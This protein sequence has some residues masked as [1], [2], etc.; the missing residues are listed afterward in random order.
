MPTHHPPRFDAAWQRRRRRRSA[1]RRW[2]WWLLLALILSVPLALRLSPP[3]PAPQWQRIDQPFPVCRQGSSTACVVDGDTVMFGKRR[4]RLTG[5]DAPEMEGACEA[6]RGQALD[7]RDAL[8]RWLSSAPF[9]WDGGDD[10]PR[11][12]YARELRGVRRGEEAL[13]DT[14]IARGLAQTSGWGNDP[15]AWCE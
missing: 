1:W 12:Q 3:Q 7:A 4:I 6:E 11:D 15:Q 5:F 2:R 14:M 13:A 9:E 8:S 10:P